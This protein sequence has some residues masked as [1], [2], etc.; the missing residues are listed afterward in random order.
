MNIIV[1]VA[2]MK[3]SRQPKDTIITYSLGSCIGLSIY[4]NKAKV[5][6]ILHYLLPDSSSAPDKAKTEP[7][8]F[9]DTA[10]PCFFKTA[11]KCGAKKNRLKIV[12]AGGSNILDQAGFFNIGKRNYLTLKRIFF[13]NNVIVDHVDVGG[14][15]YKTMSLD[16]NTGYTTILAKKGT[17]T[18]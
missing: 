5:G 1:N 13:K 16:I 7:L 11:Y 15:A 12:V 14:S 18:V 10:I 9:A 17:Y 3:I 4:D 6:G 8:K 2:D